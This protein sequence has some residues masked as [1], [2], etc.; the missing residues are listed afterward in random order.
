[1]EFELKRK[2]YGWKDFLIIPFTCDALSTVALSIQKFMTAFAAVFQVIILAN[3]VDTSRLALE[4]NSSWKLPIFW[5]ILLVLCVGWRRI[6]FVVGKVF[7]NRLRVNATAKAGMAITDKL[8]RLRYSEIEN[9]QSWNLIKR[10]CK[11]PEN[12]VRLMLQRTLNL[13]LYIIRIFGVLYIIFI[14]VWWI[15]MLTAL[16]CIPLIL[17]S[18]KSGQKN[19]KSK[20][21]AVEY[22]RR[23]QYL[24]E[25][26]SGRASVNERTLFEFS[27]II[28]EEWKK[29]YEKA[30]K[31]KLNANKV[32]TRSVRGGS[33]IVTIFSSAISVVLLFPTAEGRISIGMCV[34]LV[35]GMY[36]LVNMVGVELVKAVSQLSQ[37]REYLKD[38]SEFSKLQE[39]DGG[40]ALPQKAI[41]LFET[42]EFKNVS[43][44][45][46]G[47]DVPILRNCS[48]T[49]TNGKHYAFVG[50]NGSGKTTITKLITML[51]DNY[52]GEIFVNGK[53]LRL[54][55][56]EEI[57]V[58]F[59]GVYQ[60]FAKYSIS[61][62][63][64][65][66]LGAIATEKEPNM[67]ERIKS[68]L[69]QV[70]LWEYVQ[71]MPLGLKTPLGKILDGGV[72]LSG[73]Q[74]Q[75]LAMAR[76]II[77]RAPVLILDEPTAALDPL[78]ESKLY[79]EFAE[80]CKG[81]TSLFIS[82]RLG[83]TKLADVIFVLENGH[84]AEQGSHDALMRLDGVYAK[85]YNMQR[86]WY[87]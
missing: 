52:E 12:Q 61:V 70:G 41:P 15:G 60:D 51:Y 65:V 83:S 45:Y 78:S 25:V 43:F 53:E 37:C 86:S 56:S 17:I 26:L 18:L 13:A 66:L 32:M 39:C 22:E 36:D 19:Y 31:I 44:S 62:E 87:K 50:A 3:F 4:T 49:I 27:R 5:F 84:I 64:N 48:F 35:T 74:W 20:K 82:H 33:A 40:D 55:L 1:M 80:I 85:M 29:Q 75:K 6:S 9:E 38:L 57:K 42:L 23:Y 11:N 30:R 24:G 2:A 47:T 58:L 54:Y 16:M 67:A 28:N 77:S 8:S 73:G 10:V 68:A 7:I 72:E 69:T 59:C 71:T 21:L 46:P 34:A 63:D 81:K 14:N 79:E 76:A